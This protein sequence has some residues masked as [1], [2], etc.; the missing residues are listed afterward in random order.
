MPQS[1]LD[2]CLFIGDKVICICYVDDLLFWARDE[3]D[4]NTLAMKL[5]EVGVDLEQEDDAAGFLGVHLERDPDTGLLEMKQ[6]GL[7]DRFFE[8]LGLNVGLVNG[9]ATPAE[10]APLT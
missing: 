8:A 5:R 9:K 3:K 1:E 10:H 6:T 4:I 7:I 2:P